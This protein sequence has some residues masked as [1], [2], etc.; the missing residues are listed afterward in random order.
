[1][2]S[3]KTGVPPKSRFFKFCTFVGIWDPDG[4]EVAIWH[5]QVTF[6]RGHRC[7]LGSH[8]SSLGFMLGHIWTLRGILGVPRTLLWLTFGSILTYPLLGEMY[9]FS[10]YYVIIV[11]F[12]MYFLCIYV[13][14]VLT[15]CLPYLFLMRI[16]WASRVAYLGI[17]FIMCIQACGAKNP[18]Q[19]PLPPHSSWTEMITRRWRGGFSM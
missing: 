4:H 14:I 2:L 6:W 8:W 13:I 18:S 17:M 3:F 1:M 12:R 16:L 15:C 11:F 19:R 7:H 5:H 9:S 10:M